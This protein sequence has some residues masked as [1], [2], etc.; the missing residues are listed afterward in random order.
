MMTPF[1]G[2]KVKVTSSY[3]KKSFVDI[4]NTILDSAI[5]FHMKGT[6]SLS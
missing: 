1:L 6:A 5:K 2:Q 3:G 4:S